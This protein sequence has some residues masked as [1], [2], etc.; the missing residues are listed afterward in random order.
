MEF[1]TSVPRSIRTLVAIAV[2]T[3]LCMAGTSPTRAQSWVVE[4]QQSGFTL[5]KVVSDTAINIG[6][7]FSYT[8][9][10][11][12]PAGAT[13]VTITD[14]LP[15]TVEFLSASF[16]SPCG[17]PSVV[18]PPVNSLGGTYSLSWASVPSGCSGSF[19]ITVQFPN[20]TTCN[21]VSARNRVCVSAILVGSAIDLCTPFLS[22][23]AIAVNPWDI[24]KW[25]AG[26]AYQGGPC[27]YA[28]ADSVIT[29]QV[30]V[31][32]SMGTTG[33]LNLV[34][35]VVR[36]ILPAGAVL[37]SSSCG[38]TQ[39]GDT[40]IWT[41]PA[42]M[43]ATTL[44]NM[45]CCSFSVLYPRA[46][47]PNGSQ[48]TNKA[49]LSGVL[50]TAQP[51]CGPVADTTAQT[52]VEIKAIQSATLSKFVYTNGQ[53]GCPGKYQIWVC[54]NGTTPITSYTILD[55]IPAPL[56]TLAVSATSAG[57]T[58][59]LVGNILTITGTT[60]LGPGQCRY[61]EVTFDIPLTATVGST[62]TNCAWFTSP[63]FA[64]VKAC[65][66]FTVTAPAPKACVWKEVC[67]KQP[68]YTPGSV[69]R[70]RLRIQNVGGTAMTGV[71]L[72]DVLNPNLQYV[73][74]ASYYTGTTWNA[75][76]QPTSN[77][78][79][80]SLSHNPVSNTVTATLPPIAAVCQN[81]FYVSCGQYGTGSVP[82][83]FIEFDVK[84]VDTS[85]LGNVPN[86][87][88][89]S[90]GNLPSGVTSNVELVTVVGTAGFT[91][92]K[93]G[94]PVGGSTYA[95][96]FTSTAG[97]SIQY[98]LRFNVASTSVALRHVT[99]ADLLP[100]DNGTNDVLILGPCTP[101]GSQFDVT[102]GSAGI[103][104]PSS[105][106]WSNSV[107]SPP[108]A[109]VNNFAPTGAPG[110]MFV[111]GCGSGGTWAGTLSS[112]ARNIGF[113]FGPSPIAPSTA[114]TAEFTAT[115]SATATNQQTACNTFAANAAVRHLIAS[116]IISDQKIGQ[117][118]STP[119]CV[120]VQKTDCIDSV[121]VDVT[122]A[123]KDASGNQQYTIS[124]TGWNPNAS[125]VLMLASPHGSFSP[126]SFAIGSGAFSLTTTFTDLPPVNN[127]ITIGWQLVINGQ[128]VCRD[129][130]IRDLPPCP[131]E[132]PQDCCKEFIRQ[133]DHKDLTWTSSGAV[134]LSATLVAGP[135]PIKEFQA[136]IVSVQR[137]TVCNG[138]PS[139]WQRCFGDV[140]GGSLSIPL[141]P[142]PQL[143]SVFS[144]V[145]RWGPGECL[146]FMSG[147]TL[148]LN[149]IFPPPPTSPKCSDT[150]VFAIQYSFTD[151]KCVTCTRIR[152]DTVVR[153]Y[154]FIPWD[155][156]GWTK[157]PVLGNTA[158]AGDRTQADTAV[159]T[160]IV[161]NDATQGTLWFVNAERPDNAY[162]IVGVE[163][164][165]P[166]APLSMIRE[167][168]EDGVMTGT[169]G[170]VAVDAPPGS[171]T[172]IE[173]TVVNPAPLLEFP[174]DV[175]Y[176]YTDASGTPPEFSDVIRY[177]ARVPGA[178]TDVLA[179]D[180]GERP[181]QVRTFMVAFTNE[182]GYE[183]TVAD[184]RLIT[185]SGMKILAVGPTATDSVTGAV[186]IVNGGIP[187]VLP[188]ETVRPIYLTISGVDGPTV[189]L[190]FTT[191]DVNGQVISTG[192]CLLED[193]IAKVNNEP[194]R[195]GL[196][197][198]GVAPNPAGDLVTLSLAST[199]HA[200]DAVIR[201]VDVQ[202][203]TVADL[204][205]GT[206]V[207]GTNVIPVRVSTLVQGTY[208][209]V[210]RS[211]TGT[212]SVPLSIVR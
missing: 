26:A 92:T 184:I 10:Y 82:F 197:F 211:S 1:C 168:G 142:G 155:D 104:T 88:S 69:F 128:V 110:P 108:Q 18:S 117:L 55:T 147:A 89:L 91:L 21:G 65:A 206:L 186:S 114:A 36:D 177:T 162:T 16:T 49:T 204:W 199:M 37:Q 157:N 192:T 46:L 86:S 15:S 134:T 149:M 17:T 156:G 194:D 94:K 138:V 195:A 116:S 188:G 187:G 93:E 20:G 140:T 4:A 38:A 181:T 30:C 75:P 171:T 139:A 165:S 81:I 70:Y 193:P 207:E 167:G 153:K 98:R 131:G 150:L 84:V 96:N 6:Q 50:G 34:N 169:T 29:Y 25:V 119:A 163:V 179:E 24:G 14:L 7:P 109:R 40:I 189:E 27:P 72:T 190:T 133:V 161:M 47:F 41:L 182:N 66:A 5:K 200:D 87:F 111:G 144:R 54:N 97:G 118:E 9:Y 103:T 191:Y 61:V 60:T 196:R 120:T 43:S 176:L 58:A 172:G 73:G 53:P 32:K 129:S 127:P 3:M 59:T 208:S 212:T 52:C 100:R 151:C 125:G 35:G 106:P 137:R 2:L 107:T 13:N 130:L 45:A 99:M 105:T 148:Q 33:Q 183:A 158:K 95:T 202:G 210:V 12:I 8:V 115:V 113:Y 28:T 31:Y 141:A 170:F 102:F 180:D 80:V 173:L 175:R 136:T 146:S 71:T 56:T 19:T 135:T 132:Q 23:R 62:I 152:Y 124:M 85:A 83:Y 68:S 121:R 76:C 78:T 126:S 205:R 160:G 101:R 22:T 42:T 145:A 57:Q 122:C 63:G 209:I 166:L 48:I 203:A 112:G 77:W 39:S 74:N 174:V 159:S 198:L 44:Y 51:S 154:T 11:S 90:G 67:N 79:G 185:P 201:V 178:R 143:L 123:G 164:T 64:P